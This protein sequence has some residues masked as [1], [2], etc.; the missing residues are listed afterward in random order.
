MSHI[1][2]SGEDVVELNYNVKYQPD[3]LLI[4]LSGLEQ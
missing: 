4:C 3:L 2:N 1:C